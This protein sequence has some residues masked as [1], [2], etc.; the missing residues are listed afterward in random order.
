MA[1]GIKVKVLHDKGYPS[2]VCP[3]CGIEK[4]LTFF[5]NDLS[6]TDNV[7]SHCKQCRNE[8]RKTPH[9]MDLHR[10]QAKDYYRNMNKDRKNCIY[11]LNALLKAG[12]VKPD[13]CEICKGL[14]DTQS[15]HP[16]YSNPFEFIWL[17][18]RCH[19]FIHRR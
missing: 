7:T 8:Y 12:L 17:C 10:E 1:K 5:A 9:A 14:E 16:D 3:K 13:K 18:K 6:K 11:V 15:H 2:K 19:A 4:P